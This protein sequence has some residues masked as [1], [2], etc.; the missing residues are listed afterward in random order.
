M[1]MLN[2]EGYFVQVSIVIPLPIQTAEKQH[3]WVKPLFPKPVAL[4]GVV[5][6]QVQHPALG[7][8]EPHTAGLSPSIQPVQIPLQS[9]PTVT[10]E[11][12]PLEKRGIACV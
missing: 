8:V 10:A 9:L 3:C 4:H 2:P 7:L 11:V 5:V 12:L 6:T 1:E